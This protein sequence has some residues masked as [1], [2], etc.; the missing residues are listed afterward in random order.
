MNAVKMRDILGYTNNP[1]TNVFRVIHGEG[2]GFP[3]FICDYY[4]GILVF[5]AHSLGMWKL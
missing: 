3:G 5:Q 1:E 4:D 2:D